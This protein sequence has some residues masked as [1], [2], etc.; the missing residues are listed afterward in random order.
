MSGSISRILVHTINTFIVRSNDNRALSKSM[1]GRF[2]ER[3]AYFA[4]ITGLATMLALATG[5]T[6]LMIVDERESRKSG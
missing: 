6:D 1:S 4:R 2:A 5:L 3:A